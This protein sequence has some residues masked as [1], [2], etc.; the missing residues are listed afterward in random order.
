MECVSVQKPCDTFD[1]EEMRETAAT[2]NN[3]EFGVQTAA[4]VLLV[5]VAVS[6]FLA[7][8]STVARKSVWT[9]AGFA[10]VGLLAAYM[11]STALAGGPTQA[12]GPRTLPWWTGLGQ[13]YV[14]N[15]EAG[16]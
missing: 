9:V 14:A 8:W 7:F 3:F 11:R 1:V 4:T 16:R 6:V 12:Q 13:T 2:C 15:Y 5:V 10:G